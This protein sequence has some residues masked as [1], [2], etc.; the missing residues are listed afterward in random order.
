[1][2]RSKVFA[3]ALIVLVTVSTL[4]GCVDNYQGTRLEMN[5]T[6]GS[7]MELHELVLPSVD[8]SPGQQGYFSHYE[9]FAEI[10]H[11]G[12]VRLTTFLIQP[13]IHVQNPCLQ[14]IPD[15][16]CYS[17]VYECDPYINMERFDQLEDIFGVVT[18]PVSRESLDATQNPYG[19]E[20]FPGY[21]F[22]EWPDDLFSNPTIADPAAK[23]ARENLNQEAV[24]AFCA[25]SLP[26][27]FY[28]GNPEQLTAPRHG[29]FHGVVDGADSRTGLSIGG[30]TLMVP[31][32]LH[33]LTQLF[34]TKEPDPS[35][36]SPEMISET[37]LM[38]GPDSQIFLV[39]TDDGGIGKISDDEYRG[40]T[41]AVLRNPGALP[42]TLY[43]IIYTDID[44]DPVN[45]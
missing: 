15:R 37:Q 4:S 45:F 6:V 28:L 23:L 24:E 3:T 12:F 39:A 21:D 11:S 44:E 20:H 1:M 27:G 29:E 18:T 32:K 34:V 36:L 35:R 9:L 25:E 17:Q 26:D 30:F 42:V 13:S 8:R 19:Y 31:G 10:E 40:V 33:R 43:V 2:R 16:Y 14:Y 41:S 5:L 7:G 22:M 38:P